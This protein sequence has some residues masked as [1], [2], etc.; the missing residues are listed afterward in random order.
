MRPYATAT[1]CDWST[2]SLQNEPQMNEI[3]F[4]MNQIL[5]GFIHYATHQR[6][7][8]AKIKEIDAIIKMKKRRRNKEEIGYFHAAGSSQ[9]SERDALQRCGRITLACVPHR[10]SSS[11][12]SASRSPSRRFFFLLLL[13]LSLPKTAA[14]CLAYQV[15]TAEK[16]PLLQFCCSLPLSFISFSF[17]SAF[18][19]DVNKIETISVVRRMKSDR[20]K[21]KKNLKVKTKSRDQPDDHYRPTSGPTFKLRQIFVSG[22]RISE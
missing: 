9:P 8:V 3:F 13:S 4:E 22:P 15:I 1:L 5:T 20:R 17:L 12:T 7:R 2:C 10:S 6:S 14:T 21:K 11:R 16:G 19:L 18:R